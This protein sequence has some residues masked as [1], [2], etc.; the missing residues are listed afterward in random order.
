MVFVNLYVIV[1]GAIPPVVDF[2]EREGLSVLVAHNPVQRLLAV[3]K[4]RTA[5]D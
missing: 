5:G 1:Y 4:E 2:Y 3:G